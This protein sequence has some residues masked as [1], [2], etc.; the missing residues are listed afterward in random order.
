MRRAVATVVTLGLMCIWG[1]AGA[2]VIYGVNI[3]DGV[4]TITGSITTDGNLGQLNASD[5]T[6]WSLTASAPPDM[7]IT[8]LGHGADV[9]C[10]ASGCGLLASAASLSF[11]GGP[12]QF[13]EFVNTSIPQDHLLDIQFETGAI[14]ASNLVAAPLNFT[15]ALGDTPYV[16]GTAGAGVPEPATVLLLLLGIVGF[17]FAR[18][19]CRPCLRCARRR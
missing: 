10:A 2:T 7:T 18:A 13:F 12:L 16:V 1:V 5:L 6:A 9:L 11:A 8:S 14:L 17:G 3:S 15:I 19:A 4:H